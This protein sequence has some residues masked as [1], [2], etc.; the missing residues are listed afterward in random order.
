MAYYDCVHCRM[1]V[2][3]VI[4]IFVQ[5]WLAKTQRKERVFIYTTQ[6]EERPVEIKKYDYVFYNL[7]HFDLPFIK[8][9]YLVHCSYTMI[10]LF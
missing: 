10:N 2:W 9:L 1:V 8:I 7:T 3:A 5:T 6:Q 4:K